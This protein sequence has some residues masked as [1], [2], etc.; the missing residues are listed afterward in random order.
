MD[1]V[2]VFM[3]VSYPG[4]PYIHRQLRQFDVLGRS[5]SSVGYCHVEDGCKYAISRMH[6]N[7]G[8]ARAK[9]DTFYVS[10]SLNGAVSILEKQA[11]NTLVLVDGMKLGEVLQS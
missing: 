5:V 8:I 9:N 4:H 11:D 7:N 3:Y 10:S 2:K 6:G 1:C